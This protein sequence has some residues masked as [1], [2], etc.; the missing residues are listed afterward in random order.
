MMFGKRKETGVWF[1]ETRA[2]K[3]M[4]RNHDALYIAIG[5]LRLRIM[6]PNR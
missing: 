3:M 2:F 1:A 5:R 4:F 6:R